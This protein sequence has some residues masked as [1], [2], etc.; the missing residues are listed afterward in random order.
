MHK[1]IEQPNSQVPM[2][3]QVNALQV[4]VSKMPQFEPET[5]H[6]FHAG[7][8]CREVFRP[9]GVL[10]IGK[11][12]KKEHFYLIVSGT[13]AITTD[14][15][16]QEITGPK[17]ISSKPGTKRAVYAVTDALCMTFHRTDSLTIEDAE[18]E[19]VEDD[20]NSMFELG[21]VAKKQS[22]EVT[23]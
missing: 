5:T 21:N 14:D 7:M 17:L 3:D 20:P 19:L 1:K 22:I 11:V 2:I 13:V 8:Y 6:T 16:V 9:A 18:N 12:H 23:P 10:V 4:E 15:G